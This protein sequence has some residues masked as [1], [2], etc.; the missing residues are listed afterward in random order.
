MI[1]GLRH[2]LSLLAL[3]GAIAV[4]LLIA[5]LGADALEVPEKRLTPAEVAALAPEVAEGVES[6][7][8]LRFESDPRVEIITPAGLRDLYEKELKRTEEQ[9]DLDA[10]AEVLELLGLLEPDEDLLDIAAD[11]VELI[12]GAYD[13]RTQRLLVVESQGLTDPAIVEFI[14]AHELTHA[15]EDQRFGLRRLDRLRDDRQLA[16]EALVEGSATYLMTQYALRFQDLSELLD[17]ALDPALAESS[18]STAGLPEIVQ[19]QLLFPYLR[20]EAFVS[21]LVDLGGDWDLV[22]IAYRARLPLST[23]QVL[24]PEKYLLNERPSNPALDLDPALRP[25]W[26]RLAGG[27]IGEFD[28]IQLLRS[29]AADQRARSA[30]SGWG[31][32]RY[33]LWRRGPAEAEC[34]DDPCR[35]REVL[36]LA[37]RWDTAADAGEFAATVPAYLRGGLGASRQANDLWSLDES[38]VELRRGPRTTT[39]L[40]APVRVADGLASG[41]P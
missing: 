10:D 34:E 6:V 22:D 35:S 29:G 39:L 40:F 23:E 18:A 9:E 17:A 30:G 2:F 13:P 41:S 1:D 27:T 24:H 37:W 4:P 33:E 32:G 14:L 15:L 7:R 36:A 20:G 8:G 25:G 38:V 21:E 5:G 16:A 31:G 3:I 19:A 11:S 28:T 12:A 26:R